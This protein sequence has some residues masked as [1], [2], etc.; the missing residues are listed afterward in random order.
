MSPFALPGHT[1]TENSDTENGAFR[2]RSP[3]RRHLK[4]PGIREVVWTGY[5]ELLRYDDIRKAH[6]VTHEH[7]PK[8]NCLAMSKS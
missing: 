2:I 7:E 5:T 8:Q 1:N 4:T 6:F 3:S